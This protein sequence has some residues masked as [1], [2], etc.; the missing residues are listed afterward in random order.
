MLTR[1]LKKPAPVSPKLGYFR[2]RKLDGEYL[3][4][5]DIGQYLFLSPD[6]FRR[7]AA[8]KAVAADPFYEQAAR[9]GMVSHEAFATPENILTYRTRNNF[10]FRGPSLFIMVVTLRCNMDCIYCQASAKKGGP[11][12]LDMTEETARRVVDA[13]L[14]SSAENLCIEFQGGEPLLNWPVIEFTVAYASRKALATGKSVIFSI[15]SNLLHI[16]DEQLAFLIE[17]EVGVTTSV[18]GPEALHDMQR[19]A[20]SFARTTA[21]LKKCFEQYK[22]KYIMRLPGCLMTM[23]RHS[24]PY[25][26]EIVDTYLAL[27][28]EAVQF[29]RVSPFGYAY[30]NLADVSFSDAEYLVFYREALDYILELNRGGVRMVERTAYLMLKKMLTH[31][32]VNHMDLRTPCGAGIGQMAFNFDGNVYTCDEGRMMAM[33]GVDDFRLGSV[34]ENTLQEM[35]DSDVVSNLCVSSCLESLPACDACAYKPYCGVC[36]IYNFSMESVLISN[37]ASNDH[38]RINMGIM[39]LLMERVRTPETLAIFRSW[40]DDIIIL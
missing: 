30:D 31:E 20:G 8:G 25:P 7:A 27:G 39:D 2:F 12:S 18:D 38:C 34:Y 23:T 37:Q 35:M 1:Q 40:I 19:G 5:N 32:A 9:L 13:L 33:M 22:D 16:T 11:D 24:L 36:P 3:V 26:R 21:N 17:N 29:R 10:V 15:V 14:E 28:Q 4:T 6:E